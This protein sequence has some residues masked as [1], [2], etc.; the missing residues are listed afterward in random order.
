MRVCVFGAGAIGGHLAARFAQAADMHVSVVARGAH[1]AAMRAH[2]LRVQAPDD[3]LHARVAA[4]EDP[5]E[6]GPQDAVVVTV[7]APSLPSVAAAIA[8]LLGPDTMVAFVMNGI[9][10]WY[11]DQEGGPHD[12]TA[13]PQL[14]PG[15]ALRKA[16]GAGRTIGGVVHSP[17]TV[18]EP[19]VVRV[20]S[21]QNRVVF[22]EPDGRVTARVERL[23][24]ALRSA[25]FGVEVTPRIRDAVWSKLL[26]NLASA[27]LGVP[28][29]TG[30]AGVLAEPALEAAVHRI[31]AE[32]AA[33]AAAL[34][35]TARADPDRL[36]VQGR[37]SRHVASIVQD[38][39]LGRPMEVEAQLGVPL[40]L[41]R[42]ADVATPTLDLL[43]A[44]VRV[45]AREAGLYAG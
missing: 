39:R 29:G 32:G 27:A 16:L 33:I 40:A 12:G 35:C 30:M 9:P 3:E 26:H 14:D 2:G 34:G 24:A 15:G 13:L 38:L 42:L 20:T 25:T 31:I 7:K 17:C 1:L 36:L 37:S 44:L 5:A 21:A 11:F 45:R 8:P 4:S 18:V 19:G 41:A 10:W 22:G 23:A 28:A 6:L 43:V